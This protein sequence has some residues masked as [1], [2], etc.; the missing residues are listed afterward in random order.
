MYLF[1]QVQV[2]EDPEDLSQIEDKHFKHSLEG[3]A[4]Q[5]VE[6]HGTSGA[7]PSLLE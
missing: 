7:S 2:R 6:T 4:K 3:F 5:F 1:S